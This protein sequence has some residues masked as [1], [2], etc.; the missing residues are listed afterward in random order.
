MPRPTP[1]ATSSSA[2]QQRVSFVSPADEALI[3][4]LINH[5][6][7]SWEQFTTDKLTQLF[8]WMSPLEAEIKKND[9]YYNVALNF[10]NH[11]F[12]APTITDKQAL[13]DNVTYEATLKADVEL[14]LVNQATGHKTKRKREVYFGEYPW[15]TDR[16]TFIINGVERVVVTQI[17]RS[18]GVFF[19]AV[20][21]S[22]SQ[23]L[24]LNTD[25]VIFSAKIIPDRGSWLKIETAP[26]DG[27]IFII[28]NH[29]FRV[30]V[31]NFL[32]AVGMSVG[33]IEKA[34]AS[35]DTGPTRYIE[36]TLKNKA[37]V[38]TRDDALLD[39]YKCL[40]P[41]D[42]PNLD[43][44]QEALNSKFFNPKQYDLSKVGRYKINQRLNRQTPEDAE[45]LMLTLDDFIAIISEIIRL[46][47]T[48][49]AVSDDI[50]DL[51][52]R[53]LK[54]VGELL[55]RPFRVGLLRLEKNIRERMLRYDLDSMTPQ[56]LIN[57]RPVMIAVKTFFAS[58][59]LSQLMDQ[60][61]PLS[62]LAHK[63]RMSATGPGGLMR[64]YAKFAV[65]D[66]HV[67]HYGRICP[68]ETPE[69]ANIGLIL[70]MALFTKV[71]EYG[72]LETPY[73]QVLTQVIAKKAVGEIA[74]VDL[75]NDKEEVIVK[76][77]AKISQ[78]DATRL[79]AVSASR[80]WPIKARVVKETVHYL[81][82]ASEDQHIIISIAADVDDNGYF[83]RQY[84]EGRHLQIAGQYA[85]DQASYMDVSA[86]QIISAS[87][88]LI[89]FVEKDYVARSL[90]GANQARQA[91]PLIDPQAPIV[92]TGLEKI[93]AKHSN[94]VQYAHA[95]GTVLEATADRVVVGYANEKRTYELAH[96]QRSNQDSAINQRTVVVANQKVNAGDVL[97]EGM[98]IRDGELALGRD[99]LVALMFFD[100]DNFEDAVVISERLV[101]DDVLTNI[102]ITKYMTEVRETK[103]GP[104]ITTLDIPNVSEESLR[105]LDE[106]GIIRVG[107]RVKTGDI[108]VGKITPKGEQ[109]LSNEERLLRAIFGEKA[110]DV[111]D[112]SLRLPNGKSGKIVGVNIFSKESG[113]E[114]R[115]GVIQQIQIFV[116][117]TRKIQ[118]G[119]KLAGRHGNKGVIARILPVEDMPFTADGTPIDLILN[120]L[121]IPSR[122]NL[123]QLFEA[124]LGMAA[125]KLGM[126][127]VSPALDGVP[128]ATIVDLLQ[129]A[130]LPADGKQQLYDGRSGQPFTERSTVGPM[131]IY[132]LD[133]M[134]NDK[135]HMRST[136]PY[137][138]VTQQPLGGKSQNGGQRL[139]EMEVWALESYGAAHTLQEMLTLKSDDIYG[140]AKAYEAIIKQ[141]DVV[142]P[143]IPESFNILVKELQ[144]LGLKIDLISQNQ[145]GQ[146][147]VDAETVLAV[148]QEQERK[149]VTSVAPKTEPA[150]VIE[151]EDEEVGEEMTITEDNPIEMEKMN[152]EITEIINLTDEP[153]P[154]FVDDPDASHAT[155]QPAETSED[156]EI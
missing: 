78:A 51:S 140:R 69:G 130:D 135:V 137:A 110:K 12:E 26:K 17:I 65:R 103:L 74:R 117:Q 138:K 91:V 21:F 114:L 75:L 119:D 42:I 45:H 32:Q 100:G 147:I 71:N 80:L 50:D 141:I 8:Q 6:N 28:I 40:R 118:I 54:M 122:M 144:G 99:V 37:S 127:V 14:E 41:G 36:A 61:N 20:K 57:A 132:K 55:Q 43:N 77:G 81:D 156:K 72:F 145:D 149:D 18:S 94:Q 155:A 38:Q 9:Q 22:A 146:R 3:G 49:G 113:H 67:T 148:N 86:K 154:D 63:R 152:K 64:E 115:A 33:E 47:N 97:I 24:K 19:E 143:K 90:V 35:V 27:T 68:V 150:I 128:K 108:L 44:A 23:K 101:K 142:Q 59:Q 104:E 30:P 13:A 25:Q 153:D 109:E 79:A 15:M 106:T 56:Q 96:F 123:G 92:G 133:H 105:H 66:A 39:V 4:N 70:N 95:A 82:A 48:P 16:G 129:Q 76:A 93:I 121:G 34:F 46:N 124:H 10:S 136:G 139:G 88:S 126:K 131:Y 29:K 134:I 7:N 111:R 102:K 58:S 83:K 98:S 62:E 73:Y 116:A 85:V 1:T 125:Y 107:A 5:Q 2:T 120:P 87:T 53:R 52:N 60:V 112:T 31:T 84:E 11:R 151:E 89:P